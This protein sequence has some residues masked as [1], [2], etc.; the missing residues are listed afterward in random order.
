[1]CVTN[2]KAQSFGLGFFDLSFGGASGTNPE[3]TYP[4]QKLFGNQ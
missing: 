4:A 1:M 2:K 3:Q